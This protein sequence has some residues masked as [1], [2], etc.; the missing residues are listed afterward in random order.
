MIPWTSNSRKRWSTFH[1]Y[2][3]HDCLYLFSTS[4]DNCESFLRGHANGSLLS[5]WRNRVIQYLDYRWWTWPCTCRGNAHW[6]HIA[7]HEMTTLPNNILYINMTKTINSRKTGS[8]HVNTELE[9][10]IIIRSYSDKLISVQLGS[11]GK[12]HR[13][14]LQKKWNRSRKRQLAPCRKDTRQ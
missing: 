8:L 9:I 1:I 14:Q 11:K 12:F 2:D 6:R 5:Y 10:D 13:P 4:G 7:G 3:H